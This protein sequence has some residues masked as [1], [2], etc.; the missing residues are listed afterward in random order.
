MAKVL[1]L[2]QLAHGDR[3][4]EVQVCGSG[5]VSTVDAE[6]PAL[7]LALEQP[8]PQVACHGLAQV[9]IPIVCPLHQKINLLVYAHAASRQES[10]NEKARPR[11]ALHSIPE[12]RLSPAKVPVH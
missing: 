8:F 4:T 7:G 1:E 9:L 6:G 10:P 12:V 2:A 5:I 3:V 11:G